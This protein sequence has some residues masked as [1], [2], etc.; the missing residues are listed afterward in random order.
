MNYGKT[1]CAEVLWVLPRTLRFCPKFHIILDTGIDIC[2]N[3]KIRGGA[4]ARRPK[5]K[6]IEGGKV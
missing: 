3:H 6:F 1:K 5:M 4:S 2:K